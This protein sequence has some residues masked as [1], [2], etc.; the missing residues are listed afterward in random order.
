M[1]VARKLIPFLL[2][3]PGRPSKECNNA[4]YPVNHTFD[5]AARQP[6]LSPA[7]HGLLLLCALARFA[8]CCAPCGIISLEG[9]MMAINPAAI[10]QGVITGYVAAK[11]T[12]TIDNVTHP[13]EKSI[14][15]QMLDA[16]K[17]IH[18]AIAPPEK[19]A[20]DETVQLQP[21]PVEYIIDTDFFNHAHIC[22]LLYSATPLRIDGVFGGS[23]QK[24]LGPGWFQIDI[25]GRVSTTDAQAHTAT[26]SYRDDALGVSI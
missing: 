7:R 2:H 21:Y 14:D 24:T 17:A 4:N 11:A 26:F 20:K 25:P 3:S 8:C 10:T 19:G 5:T 18:N 6:L 9:Y 12:E 13:N 1:S 15:E 22:V 16:L 23:Y